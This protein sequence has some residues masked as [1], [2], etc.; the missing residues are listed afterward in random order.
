MKKYDNSGSISKN[1]K[2]EK[3]SHPDLKGKAVVDGVDYWISGWLKRDDNG[4][5]WYSLSFQR[6]E[7]AKKNNPFERSSA[8]NKSEPDIDDVI[9]F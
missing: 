5:P 6:H 7:G 1:K 2:K 3:D 8:E 4:Q 9:P